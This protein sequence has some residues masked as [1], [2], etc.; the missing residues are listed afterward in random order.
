MSGGARQRSGQDAPRVCRVCKGKRQT[1]DAGF[2]QRLGGH[3]GNEVTRALGFIL[4]RVPYKG[5]PQML[6]DLLEGLIQAAVLPV[7]ASL[8]HVQAGRL[9]M[10]GCSTAERIPAIA[11]IPTLAESG[12]AAAP[13]IT[14]HFVLGPP[15][16]PAEIIDRLA[17][18]VREL[19][20]PRSSSRRWTAC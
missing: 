9:V 14:A 20:R 18:A 7:G 2:Q 10:L 1:A 5:A 3:G 12:V 13:L 11:T 4:D 8:P 19:R 15:R 16:M 17:A 6:P